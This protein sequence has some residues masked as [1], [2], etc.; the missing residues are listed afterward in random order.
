MRRQ[1]L[2]KLSIS[3]QR[4]DI[5]KTILFIGD[6]ITD[7]RRDRDD[8]RYLG[9]GYVTVVAGRIGTKYPQKYNILNRGVGGDK[10]VNLLARWK[11]DC[12]NIN[13][14]YLSI[15]VGVNDAYH[16]FEVGTGV[17]E[18]LF[19]QVYKLLLNT[20]LEENPDMKIMLISPFIMHGDITNPFYEPLKKD[21]LAIENSVAEIAKEYSLNYINL[22]EVMEKCLEVAPDEYWSK[23]GLHPTIAGHTVIADT[24]VNEFET[25]F[26]V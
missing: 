17:S 22:R 1:Q 5:V 12:L 4:G 15:F 2:Y 24:I 9:N 25:R 8:D 16:E 10:S 6:S 18:N 11:K 14:D 13:P 26:L 21:V 3:N 20:A 23:D 7:A 19:R